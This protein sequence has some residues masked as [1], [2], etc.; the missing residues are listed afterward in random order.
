MLWKEKIYYLNMRDLCSRRDIFYVVELRD[1]GS[2]RER[3]LFWIGEILF[4]EGYIYSL[5]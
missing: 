5:E 1:I 2:K 4:W 3:F